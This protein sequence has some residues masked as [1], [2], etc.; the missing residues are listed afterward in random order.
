ME[1]EKACDRDEADVTECAAAA[2]V[3]QRQ[4][5]SVTLLRA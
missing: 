4:P 2:L 1:K 3:H 5:P